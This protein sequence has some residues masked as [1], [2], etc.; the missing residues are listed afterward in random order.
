MLTGINMTNT[1]DMP[2]NAFQPHFNDAP[3]PAGEKLIAALK[4]GYGDIMSAT[5]P[6]KVLGHPTLV[7]TEATQDLNDLN[8]T[9]DIFVQYQSPY[10]D[11]WDNHEQ[12][13]VP[14]SDMRAV[15]Q[16]APAEFHDSI[17]SIRTHMQQK[18]YDVTRIEKPKRIA[19]F[20]KAVN[21][22]AS[23]TG[24]AL[25]LPPRAAFPHKKGRAL[26]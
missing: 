15:E 2:R 8:A 10:G 13:I 23:G 6:Y 3:S 7:S 11:N 17:A 16:M 22:F 20:N 18:M 21:G 12:F 4:S 19:A 5:R 9:L 14:L 1:P 25:P 24:D 26:S